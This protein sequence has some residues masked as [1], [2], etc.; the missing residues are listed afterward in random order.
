MQ[1]ASVAPSESALASPESQQ[2]SP[3]GTR[4]DSPPPVDEG[5]WNELMCSRWARWRRRSRDPELTPS[6]RRY[7]D[8]R[9]RRM[10]NSY[11]SRL[12]G[13]SRAGVVV[14]CGCPGRRAVRYYTC[15][16]HL[17]C[18]ACRKSRS[19]RMRAR[20]WAGLDAAFQRERRLKVVLVTITVRH[21]GCVE[22]DRK[23]LAAGWRRFYKAY[24]RRFRGFAYV[25][26][27][28]VTAGWDGFGHPHAHIVALW[29]WRDWGELRQMWLRACPQSEQIHFRASRTVKHA[30]RYVSKYVSKGVQTDDFSPEL[31]ARVLAGTYG[32]RWVFSSVRFWAPFEPLCPCCGQAVRRAMLRDPFP[33]A[34]H[35]HWRRYDDTDGDEPTRWY[36]TAISELQEPDERGSSGR[37]QQPM[38]SR[39]R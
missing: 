32:T 9:A 35:S 19:R 36:Q 16:Q 1:A 2:V 14:K 13:C 29:P 34:A 3:P 8:R 21:S 22:T 6:Q 25:G 10:E 33:D 28:E 37:R 20:I 26:T 4:C 23:N 30:A 12:E 38:A 24:W 11:E 15:R 31:R 5:L 27:H 39:R 18:S 7:A 17:L